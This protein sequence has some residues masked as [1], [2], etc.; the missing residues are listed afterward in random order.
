M[1][2]V[3]TLQNYKLTYFV[4]RLGTEDNILVMVINIIMDR[5]QSKG[6]TVIETYKKITS[7]E[8]RLKYW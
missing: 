4:L 3:C 1:H 7:H 5:K 8:Y 6:V 2:M